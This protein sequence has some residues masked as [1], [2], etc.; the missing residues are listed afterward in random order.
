MVGFNAHIR[1]MKPTFYETP[2]VL[3]G[4]RVYAAMHVFD[5]MIYNL[6]L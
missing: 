4:I 1:S 5:G 6:M 3:K 2:K